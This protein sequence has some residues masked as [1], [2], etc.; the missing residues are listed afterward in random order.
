MRQP[1]MILDDRCVQDEASETTC[2]AH[3][4]LRVNKVRHPRP[5]GLFDSITCARSSAHA[6]IHLSHWSSFEISR[7]V[8]CQQSG[9]WDEICS[10]AVTE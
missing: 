1:E 8:F 6:V 7:E 3:G 10:E 4:A 5:H 9:S 2:S